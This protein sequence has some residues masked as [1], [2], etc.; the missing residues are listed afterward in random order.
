MANYTETEIIRAIREETNPKVFMHLYGKVFPKVK[1]YIL[2]NGG[3][4]DESKDIFQDALLVFCSKVKANT[5]EHNTEIDGFIYSIS[6]NM[7][8]NRLKIR[9]R[10]SPLSLQEIDAASDIDLERVLILKE[11]K[12]TI[13][14]LLGKLG[15]IC[16]EL[17]I[18]TIYYKLSMAEI[19]EKMGFSNEN[20]AKTKNYKCKQRLIQLVDNKT[21]LI[22]LLR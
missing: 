6:R 10:K 3:D 4:L 12:H 21:E 5:Y 14:L 22:E 11:Q 15:D 8:I 13:S 1:N 9:N 19:C 2:K 16:K 18:N 17:L 7:W 20:V